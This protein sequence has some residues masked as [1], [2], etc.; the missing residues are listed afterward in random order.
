MN[1]RILTLGLVMV[2]CQPKTPDLKEHL[3][4][5]EYVTT[6]KVLPDRTISVVDKESK[7]LTGND[8]VLIVDLE[9]KPIFK[10]GQEVTDLHSTRS[11]LIQLN[12]TDSL[13]R[14]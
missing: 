9:R 2:S 8:D 3:D 5:W 13:V 14:P 1:L 7:L 4:G 10:P 12:S 6:F 11:L